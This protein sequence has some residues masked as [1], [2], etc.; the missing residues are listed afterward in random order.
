MKGGFPLPLS[1]LRTAVHHG[2][3]AVWIVIFLTG[4]LCDQSQDRLD[5]IG[6]RASFHGL[7]VVLTM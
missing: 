6:L 1:C 3:R 4:S 2:K 7:N 5:G